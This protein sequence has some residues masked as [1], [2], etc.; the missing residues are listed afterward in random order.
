MLILGLMGA[1][2][3]PI[4][5]TKI[6]TFFLSLQLVT[7]WH[8]DDL[9]NQIIKL[10]RDIVVLGQELETKKKKKKYEKMKKKCR[11]GSRRYFSKKCRKWRKVSK[12]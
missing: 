4:I 7:A 2:V 3:A 1:I 12:K 10:E 5:A 9:N 11:K 6:V 8:F